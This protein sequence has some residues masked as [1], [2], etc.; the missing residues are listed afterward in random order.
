MLH[1]MLTG[2]RFFQRENPASSV[3][4]IL[5]EQPPVPPATP[6]PL[7]KVVARCLEKDPARRYQTAHE[8]QAALAAAT[9][10]KSELLAGRRAWVLAAASVAILSAAGVLWYRQASETRLRMRLRNELPQLV[11]HGRH[12]TAYQLLREGDALIQ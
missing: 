3:A 11:D 12:L 6:S 9:T 5:N 1:E 4:A 8:L 2:R 7:Q 10:P